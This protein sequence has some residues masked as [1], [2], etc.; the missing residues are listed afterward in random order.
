MEQK[1]EVGA[2]DLGALRKSRFE[3]EKLI[4]EICDRMSV[5]LDGAVGA[6]RGLIHD[7]ETDPPARNSKSRD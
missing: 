3:R 5:G 7:R 4:D 1:R 2:R 6:L